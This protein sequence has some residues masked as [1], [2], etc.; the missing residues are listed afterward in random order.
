MRRHVIILVSVFVI[1]CV[2]T[3]MTLYVMSHRSP[4]MNATVK[5]LRKEGI[6]ENVAESIERGLTLRFEKSYFYVKDERATFL[7]FFKKFGSSS[8]NA[9]LNILLRCK[10]LEYGYVRNSTHLIGYAHVQNLT[11]TV[12]LDERHTSYNGGTAPYR[13]YARLDLANAT[14][15]YVFSNSTY[16]YCLDGIFMVKMNSTE[17][18]KSRVERCF[19]LAGSPRS[20]PQLLVY[21]MSPPMMTKLELIGIKHIFTAAISNVEYLGKRSMKGMVC[22]MYSTNQIVDLS[23]IL[24]NRSLMRKFLRDLDDALRLHLN[25]SYALTRLRD[26]ADMVALAGVSKWNITSEFCIDKSGLVSYLRSRVYNLEHSMFSIDV[27]VNLTESGMKV[28]ENYVNETL[29]RDALRLAG[30][31]KENADTSRAMKVSFI[32]HAP[33]IDPV[34]TVLSSILILSLHLYESTSMEVSNTLSINNNQLWIYTYNVGDTPITGMFIRVV[35]NNNVIG[36]IYV[37]CINPVPHGSLIRIHCTVMRGCEIAIN[38]TGRCI[39]SGTIGR[40]QPEARYSII[41]DVNFTGGS[42]EYITTVVPA[43][44][45]G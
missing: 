4:H 17:T 33:F 32:A 42:G 21:V 5:T 22:N 24:S 19:K 41:I 31:E 1:A 3:F 6:V 25:I 18:V 36:K 7:G 43:T 23:N 27:R 16:M 44:R 30:L 29:L 26:V 38:G 40:F 37:R 39:V 11:I 13:M 14:I 35:R 15:L 8:S 12:K 45:G 28:Y 9:T 10:G 20:G 2:T 34:A